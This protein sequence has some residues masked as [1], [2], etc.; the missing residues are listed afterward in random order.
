M[1]P[2]LISLFLFCSVRATEFGA[3]NPIVYGNNTCYMAQAYYPKKSLEDILPPH[4]SIP[5]EETMNFFYPGAKPVDGMT[6]F[7][8][9]FCY[10]ENIHDKFTKINVP[11]QNELMF[12]FPVIYNN[13]QG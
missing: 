12:V 9:S 2:L 11:N 10:G 3:H 7:L 5:N 13:G 1:G 4:M 6:P 8:M